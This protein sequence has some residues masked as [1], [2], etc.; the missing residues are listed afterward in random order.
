MQSTIERDTFMSPMS[1]NSKSVKDAKDGTIDTLKQF[2]LVRYSAEN[3][4]LDLSNMNGDAILSQLGIFAQASTSSKL[5]PALM[6]LAGDEGLDVVSVNLESNKL[7]DVNGVTLLAQTFPKLK[8]LSL[9]NNDIKRYRDLEAW[10]AKGKLANLH[11]LIM[12][13]NPLREL[14]VQKGKE[15]EYRSEMTRM[16]PH[17]KLLDGQP[18][19]QGI[20]FDVGAEDDPSLGKNGKKLALPE[21]IKGAFFENEAVQA[22]A[23]AFLAKFFPLYDSNRDE[24]SSLYADSAIFSMSLNINAPRTR[25][26]GAFA[27]ASWNDYIHSSRNLVRITALGKAQ[28]SKYVY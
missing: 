13:G 11:E 2:L 28:S 20:S 23:S 3:K 27:S 4:M 16:F 18:V 1:S 25:T 9:A 24:L 26:S 7:K 8:N 10:A 12:A 19:A 5:F 22:T 15:V 14:E 17:L 6:K 21:K